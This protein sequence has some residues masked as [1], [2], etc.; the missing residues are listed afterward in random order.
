MKHFL[1]HKG[2][3]NLIIW[4]SFGFVL[5]IGII[6][7]FLQRLSVPGMQMMSVI[8]MLGA[9]FLASYLAV[10]RFLM[11]EYRRPSMVD[12]NT[13]ALLVAKFMAVIFIILFV[14]AV[15]IGGISTQDFSQFFEL[16]F[17]SG[18]GAAFCGFLLLVYLFTYLNFGLL[19]RLRAP[20]PS[21]V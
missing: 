16:K 14:L 20:A 9:L 17:L 7:G 15:L 5:L 8:L 10:G 21:P 6:V 19:S 18:F 1:G 4:L 2:Y 13:V 12:T 11:I 3:A